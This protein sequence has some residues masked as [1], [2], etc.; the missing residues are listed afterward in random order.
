VARG[1]GRQ[2]RPTHRAN[3]ALI[4][5]LQRE[6]FIPAES[7]CVWDF[8]AT[9]LNLGELTPS[10]LKFHI[11]GALPAAMHPGQIIERRISPLPGI[12]LRWVT[13]ITDVQ[14]GVSF[15]DEQHTGPY[16]FWRHEQTF[17]AVR[18][19]VRITDRVSYGVGWGPLGW[20]AEK[21]WVRRQLAQIFD[22]RFQRV[23][24]L[25]KRA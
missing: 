3:V 8:F 21:F 17:Q 11:V 19:G 18:G 24:A 4:R 5:Q 9:P 16:K 13:E 20:L 10:N 6:Q 1:A 7:V 2:N 25:F 15:V 22:Y 14:A 23:Q 12:W